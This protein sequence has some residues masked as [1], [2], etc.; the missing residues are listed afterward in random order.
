MM[1]RT[2]FVPDPPKIQNSPQKNPPTIIQTSYVEDP[3]KI[4]SSPQKNL[5]YN[6]VVL[7]ETDETVYQP[8]VGARSNIEPI[9]I[10]RIPDDHIVDDRS[11]CCF[12]I[13]SVKCWIF[14]IVVI[15]LAVVLPLVI[16]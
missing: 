13:K 7:N 1:Q 4:Q 5:S 8:L 2:V 10:S 11:C 14:F 3:P 16:P 6:Q 12:C 9:M 15:S